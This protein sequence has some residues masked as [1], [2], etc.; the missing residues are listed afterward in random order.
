MEPPGWGSDVGP[1]RVETLRPWR[2]GNLL[3]VVP[4][5]VGEG[6]QSRRLAVARRT[7]FRR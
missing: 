7:C 3:H 4:A 2:G 5:H 6:V 1:G